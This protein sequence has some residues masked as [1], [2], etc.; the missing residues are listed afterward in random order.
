MRELIKKRRVD[1]SDIGSVLTH[2]QANMIVLPKDWAYD[3][4][5]FAQRNPQAM[6]I[7]DITEPGDGE[8]KLIAPGSDVRTDIP[9]I[10]Y[11]K[12]ASQG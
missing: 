12:T 5:V 3:F 10:A 11:G 1:T 6:P 8:A 9:D 2:V 7:L 4:L